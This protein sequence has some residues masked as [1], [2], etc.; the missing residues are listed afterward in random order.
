MTKPTTTRPTIPAISLAVAACSMQLSTAAEIQLLPAGR[1][2]A[3]DGRPANAPGWFIDAAL[4][5]VLIEAA[6]ARTDPYVVDYEHQ[7]LV[8]KKSGGPAPAAAWFKT[9]EWRDGVGLFA[10]DVEWTPA[11]AGYIANREYRFISPVIAYDERTGAVTA[12]YMAAITNDPAIDGMNSELLSAA[13][14]HFNLPPIHHAAPHQENPQMDELLK[15]LL[16][17]LGLPDDTPEAEAIKQVKHMIDMLKK[18]PKDAQAAQDATAVAAA[19]FTLPPL[20]RAHS[21]MIASLSAGAP[22]PSKFVP[23]AV[24]AALHSQVAQLSSQVNSGRVGDIVKKALAD[25]KLFPAQEAWACELGA[26]NMA[27]LTAFIAT[28]PTIAALSGM[29]TTGAPPAAGLG[30]VALTADQKALCQALSLNETQY[31]AVL[32]GIARA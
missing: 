27:A 26:N 3:R 31:Q 12:L 13:S 30:V 28:A 14:L 20:I 8:A 2:K 16:G 29:Q 19:T 6:N 17:L 18:D 7:T 24:V 1:F 10:V 11:A 32:S 21:A 5:A 22:D 4:A 23:I 9:L 25:G 15:Q